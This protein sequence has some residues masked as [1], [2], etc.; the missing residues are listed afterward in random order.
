MGHRVAV[1]FGI[2]L[3]LALSGQANTSAGQAACQALQKDYDDAQ[4]AYQKALEKARTP[5]DKQKVQRDHLARTGEF[6]RRFMALARKHTGSPA[7]VDAL[8]W[9]ATHSPGPADPGAGLRSEALATLARDHLQSDQVGR[10]CTLLVFSIDPASEEFLR[11]I[12]ARA[13]RPPILARACASLAVNLKHRARL[14]P[15]L[16]EDSDSLERYVQVFGKKAVRQLLDSDPARLR[17]ESEKH[18]ERLLEK[19][20][21]LPHPTHGN[22]KQ[23][24]RHH[25]LAMRKPVKVNSLAPATTGEDVAG[26]RLSLADFRGQVVL[27]DFGCHALAP[28]RSV[29]GYQRELVK[30]LAGKPFVLLGVSGDG[31]RKTLQKVIEEGTITWRCIWDGEFHGPI[32]TRW[33]V[34]VRPSLFLIDHKGVIRHFFAG[35][36]ERKK[37]DVL[38][39]ELVRDA[40]KRP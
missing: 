33:S 1:A 27:L 19:Y 17:V 30:R 2:G 7:A 11:N 39:D 24:A 32:A 28:C 10:L 4:A 21:E 31:D 38:I 16:T 18:F 9:V 34:N 8:F 40:P 6:S 20:G 23:Y 3:C 26:K 25:L 35:W 14:I 15:A 29:Y 37:V 36:P 13:K 22:L 5:E 12:L